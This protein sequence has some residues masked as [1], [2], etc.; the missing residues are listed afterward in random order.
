MHD[1]LPGNFSNSVLP[2]PIRTTY[3]TSQATA[4]K[5]CVHGLYFAGLYFDLLLKNGLQFPEIISLS[6]S[7]DRFQEPLSLITLDWPG[8]MRPG[9]EAM[10]HLHVLP[11]LRLR[12]AIPPF[13]HTPLWWGAWR[14]RTSV[15]TMDRNFRQR[16]SVLCLRKNFPLW[17]RRQMF[18]W[19]CNTKK[20]ARTKG[21]KKT[22]VSN[23]NLELNCIYCYF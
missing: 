11:T 21:R 3:D 8:V 12:R 2:Y 5:H 6:L 22:I 20:Q 18:T 17:E 19:P 15:I 4:P 23:L 7:P 9:R 1:A 14:T 13:P 10:T 16:I